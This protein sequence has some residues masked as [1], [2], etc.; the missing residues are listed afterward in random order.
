MISTGLWVYLRHMRDL[1]A[2]LGKVVGDQLTMT[3]SCL[4]LRTEQAKRRWDLAQALSQ[5][6]AGLLQ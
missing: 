5:K 1:I 3:G 6:V 2:V 4:L